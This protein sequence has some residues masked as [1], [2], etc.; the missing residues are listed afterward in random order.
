MKIAWLS[1]QL[2]GLATLALLASLAIG[3]A[4]ATAE[5]DSGKASRPENA[6]TSPTAKKAAFPDL[7]YGLTSFGAAIVGD[8][9][10]VYGGHKGEAHSY[11]FEEQSGTLLHLNL[12]SDGTWSEVSKGPR[13]QGLAM[14][15]HGG[16]LYR[17]GGFSA[18]NKEGEDRNL[19][20]QDSAACFDPKTK[21]WKELPALPEPRSSHDAA[22]LGDKLYVAGGWALQGK[23]ESQWHD[24]AYVLDL[25]AEQPQWEP[26]PKPNFQR[27]A[28]SLA[29]HNGKIYAIGGMESNNKPSLR[30]DIFD[31][32][33]GE[34]SEGPSLQG[35][36]MEGF[37]NSAFAVN[38]R[39]YVSTIKGR[40]Q[41]LSEDGKSW[42][43]INEL[44]DARFFHRMLPYQG[45]LL[46]VGGANMG[47]GK[48][49]NL[50]LVP[51]K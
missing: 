35:E 40:L 38:G 8:D 42:E 32:K 6:E 48:F 28:L 12:A 25:T 1:E 44:A 11:S 51:A 3:P 4:V 46:M 41:R 34:W 5:E 30:V 20:S 22:V 37:G 31:P 15:A 33:T 27:R 14:V 36:G 18:L 49:T 7:P 24:T 45:Q 50:D 26:L 29:A 10:Y 16:K 23:K 21:T 19:V 9:L 2:G 13:L 43:V 47:T 17:V 39:L